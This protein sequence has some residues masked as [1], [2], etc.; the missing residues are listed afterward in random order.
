MAALSH[1][2]RSLLYMPASNARALEKAKTLDAD[3]VIF[4]LEDGVVPDAKSAARDQAVSAL[5]AGGFGAREVIVRI[6]APGSKW[7]DDDLAALAA[8]GAA[9]PDAVLVPKVSGLDDLRVIARA[10]P[11]LTLWA[12]IETTAA[13]MN[14]AEI[15]QAARRGEIRAGA[16]VLGTNDLAKEIGCRHDPAKPPLSAAISNTV[17]AAR[18][19]NIAILD[20]VYNDIAD[21]EGFT[22]SCALAREM[23]FDGKTLIHPSQI[24]IC[25]KAFSPS[26]EEIAQARV[27]VDAFARPE[28][29]DKGVI[30]LNGEMVER[31]HLDI[32]RRVIARG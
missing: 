23:G 26:D 11:G 4:D 7:A 6:N 2:R 24:D 17:I 16:W 13:V 30:M 18:A 28:N 32:A 25:N 22:W 5:K 10:A 21:L 14:L 20:G 9:A 1:P 3:G 27:I 29:Q 15:G 19:N 8:L 12:M 31:L